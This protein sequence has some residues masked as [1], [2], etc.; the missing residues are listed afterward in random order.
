[1][2]QASLQKLQDATELSMKTLT[3]IPPEKGLGAGAD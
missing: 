3:A 2:L 1:M